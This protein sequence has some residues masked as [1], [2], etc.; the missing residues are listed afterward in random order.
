MGPFTKM[1]EAMGFTGPLKYNKWVSECVCV[2][3]LWGCSCCFLC[4]CVCVRQ[5][6][7]IAALRMYTCCVERPSYDHF[8]DSRWTSWRPQP[9]TPDP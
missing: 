5:K 3:E 2:C 1:I 9:L 4:V 8:F 6:I 7:K